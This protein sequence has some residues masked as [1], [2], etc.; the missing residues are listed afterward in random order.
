MCP[1]SL[2]HPAN[3]PFL[4]NTAVTCLFVDYCLPEEWKLPESRLWLSPLH[5]AAPVTT[6]NAVKWTA[7]P[8]V[9]HPLCLQLAIYALYAT[10][11]G[12]IRR[13]S[14]FAASSG[15]Y[16]KPEYPRWWDG[17]ATVR[18][19]VHDAC[20]AAGRLECESL[21]CHGDT[22]TEESPGRENRLLS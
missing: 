13:K 20:V 5:R 6:I 22:V 12:N 15:R 1:V 2:L 3:V 10:E 14:W 17:R 9:L 16:K 21:H 11:N 19:G 4:I 7:G 18:C 8:L